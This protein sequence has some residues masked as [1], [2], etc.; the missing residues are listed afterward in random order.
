MRVAW[1]SV[2]FQK[3]K[4]VS[5]SLVFLNVFNFQNL[6]AEVRWGRLIIGD[7][8]LKPGGLKK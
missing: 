7:C 6:F 3:A 8:W 1:D 4:D 5:A 2:G